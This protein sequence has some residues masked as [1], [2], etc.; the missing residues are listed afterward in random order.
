MGQQLES[1][2]G[3]WGAS[4]FLCSICREGIVRHVSTVSPEKLNTEQ[5]LAWLRAEARGYL[6]SFRILGAENFPVAGSFYPFSRRY[7][8][9]DAMLYAMYKK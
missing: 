8:A 7:A 2:P 6:H 1:S 4:A 9:R 5:I 3:E